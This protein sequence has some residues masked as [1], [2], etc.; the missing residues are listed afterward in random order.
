MSSLN[1]GT[2]GLIRVVNDQA[3]IS[4]L[5]ERGPMSRNELAHATG[6]SKPTAAEVLRR[7][8]TADLLRVAGQRSG[9]R[10]PHA[11]VYELTADH[12][13]SLAVDIQ[14]RQ[15]SSVVVDIAGAP[16]P[17]V[18]HQLTDREQGDPAGATLGGALRRACAAAGVED[19]AITAVAV[20]LQASVDHA[21][22]SLTFLEDMPGWPRHAVSATLSEVFGVPILLENDANLAA[23]A[24]R[25][26]GAGRDV[27][28]FALLWLDEGVGLALDLGGAVHTG[29]AGAA[30]EI[31]YLE[32]AAGAS[33][34]E[35]VSADA[36]RAATRRHRLGRLV[37]AA[38]DH[39]VFAELAARIGTALLPALAVADPALVILH[40]PTGIDGGPPLAAATARWL[41]EQT[42]W[43][44]EVVPP[45]VVDAPVLQGAR[46]RLVEHT[47]STMKAAVGALP[48]MARTSRS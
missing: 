45:A 18:H 6:L 47:V 2:P 4:L 7:L 25:A 48:E 16:H 29:S 39:P 26:T 30:G 46:R 35:L 8:E 12:F 27:Q 23:V 24:E 11:V 37:E 1:P 19:D 14:D 34:G 40:G 28:S 13:P 9:R 15:V 32:S 36:V 20:G 10:G 5:L 43:V 38:G 44:A 31:G 42:R 3:A 41:R 22:D 21:S 33:I 17:V